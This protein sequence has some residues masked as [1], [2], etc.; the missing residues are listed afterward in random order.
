MDIFPDLIDVDELV[1][2]VAIA[3]LSSD[4]GPFE[5]L[6]GIFEIVA[7]LVFLPRVI[8]GIVPMGEELLSF[9][10]PLFRS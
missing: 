4:F 9:K 3:V 2:G 8:L 5:K 1:I 7:C 10:M 6:I